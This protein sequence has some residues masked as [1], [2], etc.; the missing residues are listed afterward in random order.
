MLFKQ[1]PKDFKKEID[2]V[3][4]YIECEGKFVLLYRQMHKHSGN[5]FGL[6]AGKVDLGESVGQAMVREIKEETGLNILPSQLKYLDSLFVRNEGRDFL[7]HSF[8]VHFSKMP[9]IVINPAEHQKY[10]WVTP[11]EAVKMNL[12]HD[13]ADCINMHYKIL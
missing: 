8:V 13:L 9:D 12:V 3:A 7:Y 4:C 6:P 2:V 1:E 11:A 10:I 5:T